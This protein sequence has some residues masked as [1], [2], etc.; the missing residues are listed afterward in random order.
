MSV[1]SR[2][3]AYIKR[4]GITQTSISQKTGIRVDTMSA[5]MNG[6]RKMSADEYELICKAIEKTPNDF[7]EVEV[8]PQKA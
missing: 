4:M 6:K 8:E 1:Q 2:I 5:L 3:S 7:I